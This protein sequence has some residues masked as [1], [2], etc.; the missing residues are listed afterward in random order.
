MLPGM[1]A[2]WLLLP[3]LAHVAIGLVSSLWMTGAPTLGI[4]LRRPAPGPA[5]RFGVDTF[6][7]R[8]D[9]RVHHR[10]KPDL[11]ANWCFLIAR[12]IVQF[13][14]FARFE[15][16]APR[17]ASPEYT[18]LVRRVTAR[19]PWRAPLPP[20]ARIVIPGFASL[21]ALTREEEAAVKAGLP[22]RLWSI[23]RF[24]N[25]RLTYP[26]R[27]AHQARVAAEIVGELQ[28]GRPAQ[29]FITDFPCLGINHSVLAFAYAEGGREAVDFTVFDPNDPATPGII[30]F[31]R[32]D[33][34]YRPA[35]LCGVTVPHFRAFR[36]YC[37]PLI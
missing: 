27:R 35:P 8:N 18:A 7:F 30:R 14:R 31:D 17:L 16:A 6:A 5:L 33:C 26:H 4:F 13:Q 19:A 21:H 29:L 22:P 12:A 2:P 3:L 9:S 34:R 25:W 20:E 15:P 37:A 11:Y 28:A 1:L 10:G 24:S 32:R 23:I 36:Q